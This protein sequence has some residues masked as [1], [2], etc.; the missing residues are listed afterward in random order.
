M[1]QNQTLTLE[2][3]D[4]EKDRL[5]I[6]ARRLNLTPEVY[7]RHLLRKQLERIRIDSSPLQAL[8]NLR[9]IGRR[10][11]S[12]DAVALVRQERDNLMERGLF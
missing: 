8:R 7:L 12:I 10:T 5:I 9:E 11:I 1:S 2:L 4:E 3:S 6:L